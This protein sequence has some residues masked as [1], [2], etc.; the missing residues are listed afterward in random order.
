[1]PK[2]QKKKRL[3]KEI[4]EIIGS[5][6][7]EYTPPSTKKKNKIDFNIPL[8]MGDGYGELSKNQFQES[9]ARKKPKKSKSSTT[10]KKGKGVKT[11]AV[12]KGTKVAK[13]G[14]KKSVKKKAP[15]KPKKA[16]KKTKAKG[17]R[18]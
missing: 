18:K 6:K 4:V 13:K 7:W 12:K 2:E 15:A 10:V 17:K 3:P 9:D 11:V 14:A 1:M 16:A 8:K 5:T